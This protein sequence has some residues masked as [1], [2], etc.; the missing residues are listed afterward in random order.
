MT[1]RN[2]RIHTDVLVPS[3]ADAIAMAQA[4]EERFLELCRAYL[5]YRGQELPIPKSLDK[6][7]L[8]WREMRVRHKRG[9]F[10]HTDRE[11]NSLRTIA[12]WTLD[13]NSGLRGQPL[14]KLEW[15]L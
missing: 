1:R 11:L 15:S 12:Q 2:G 9:D 6:D 7:F 10:R 5:G 14:K 8:R 13:V 4:V 3:S